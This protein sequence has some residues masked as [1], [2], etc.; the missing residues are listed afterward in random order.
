[1][2][3][4]NDVAKRA[5]LIAVLSNKSLLDFPSLY[6]NC[7]REIL[8][9]GYSLRAL[10]LTLEN[11][12]ALKQILRSDKLIRM[13]LVAPDSEAAKLRA[14]ARSYREP[15]ELIK[16]I[17]NT[18]EW[19]KAFNDDFGA[20]T[21]QTNRIQLRLTHNPPPCSYFFV[22]DLCFLSLYSH[23][24][25]GSCGPCLVYGPGENMFG[26]NYFDYLYENFEAEWN[27]ALE[28]T[29]D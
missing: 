8:F 17:R 13:L 4:I 1:M 16:E 28:I 29:D 12:E 19:T 9:S 11:R 25:T 14:L 24:A 27:E 18:I 6:R 20:H 22:D 7:H 23:L 2:S 10:L 15:D 21:D 26:N 5:G 3:T